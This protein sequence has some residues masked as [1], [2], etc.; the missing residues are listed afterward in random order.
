MSSPDRALDLSSCVDLLRDCAE[1]GGMIYAGR[2]IGAIEM[3]SLGIF[4][5]IRKQHQKAIHVLN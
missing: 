1:Y 5:I 4:G 2:I 3:A